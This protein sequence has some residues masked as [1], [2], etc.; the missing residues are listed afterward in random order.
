ML[1][2]RAARKG[3]RALQLGVLST[4]RAP[5]GNRA[6]ESRSKR[7]WRIMRFVALESGQCPSNSTFGT[8][9]LV[10]VL[11]DC[12]FRDIKVQIYDT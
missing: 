4:S 7:F 1:H 2:K 6:S 11:E 9:K 10:I 12:D 5:S 3:L 8:E